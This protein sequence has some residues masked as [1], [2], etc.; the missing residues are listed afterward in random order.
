[1]QQAASQLEDPKQKDKVFDIYLFNEAGQLCKVNKLV[2][3]RDDNGKQI[4]KS[5]TTVFPAQAEAQQ[6]GVYSISADL[7][8][9][10]G[11]FEKQAIDNFM[12]ANQIVL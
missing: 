4:N 5:N 12:R 1:M 8:H 10:E 2:V 11:S 9:Q 3:G 6:Y 7:E